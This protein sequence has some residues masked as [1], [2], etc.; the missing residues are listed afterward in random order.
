MWAG[1]AG[2]TTAAGCCAEA[3]GG[4]VAETDAGARVAGEPA[5]PKSGGSEGMLGEVGCCATIADRELWPGLGVTDLLVFAFG[6]PPARAMPMTSTAQ[7]A[8]AVHDAT[9]DRTRP[10]LM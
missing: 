2:G 10:T 1:T 6:S 3:L 9:D 8:T 4:N 7:P 5:A